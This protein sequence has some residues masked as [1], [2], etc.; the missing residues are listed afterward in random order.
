MKK[1]LI[2]IFSSILIFMM[3]TA[4][5]GLPIHY[6][7]L[8]AEVSD[9]LTPQ[10]ERIN[11]LEENKTYELPLNGATGFASIN[12]PV[13]EQTDKNANVVETLTPGQPFTIIDETN[14]W[15]Q[16]DT[17]STKGY[18]VHAYCFINLPDILPSII[19]ENT[20][21][22]AS[23][24]RSAGKPIPQITDQKLYDTYHYNARLGKNEFSVPVLYAMAEK[25]AKAQQHA[26]SEGNTLVI[27]EGYRPYE[28]QSAVVKNV[29]TL[30]ENDPEVKKAISEAPWSITWFILTGVSNHQ[31]GYA[32]DVSLASITAEAEK[33]TGP[34][35]YVEFTGYELYEMP[36]PI[37]ELSTRS[38][39]LR[40]PVNTRS[41][42]AWRDVPP[43]EA[44][45]EPALALRTYC[46]DAGLTP[47][48]SEWWHFNDLDCSETVD[49]SGNAG[50]FKVADNMSRS[51]ERPLR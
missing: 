36:S 1:R 28:V 30:A 39:S 29:T 7:N 27:Y 38:V 6:E 5:A 18:V 22:R 24:M 13:R 11:Y 44:M 43:A 37:H 16:I 19:Y 4:C 14:E 26:R 25:I 23:I 12:L 15:W 34:Y 32:I 41:K 35:S 47:I 20:N 50:Q 10:N 33:S 40:Y 46:T 2:I 3:S 31:R 42:T 8:V 17:G 49:E 45:N 51:P 21:G 9:M 48:A